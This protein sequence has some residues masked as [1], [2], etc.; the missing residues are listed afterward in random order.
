MNLTQS[1]EIRYIIIGASNTLIGYSIGV[2]LFGIF[3]DK[4]HTIL[5]AILANILSIS[6]SFTSH[7]L[8]V[9]KTKGNWRN[10]FIKACIVYGNTA[11]ISVVLIWFF[12]DILNFSIWISQAIT[13]SI[14]FSL[15]YIGHKKFTFNDIDK[16]Q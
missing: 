12:V 13:I 16:S 11:G 6:V 10:E 3:T 5:I 1:R 8:F 7:K 4:L 14:T 15:S 9:F 2:L